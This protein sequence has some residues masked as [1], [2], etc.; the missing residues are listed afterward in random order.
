VLHFDLR[1]AGFADLDSLYTNLSNQV[2]GYFKE[3]V[4]RGRLDGACEAERF[5]D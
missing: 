1:I 5:G 3:L 2:E 4:V